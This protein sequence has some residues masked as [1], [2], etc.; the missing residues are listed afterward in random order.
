[1]QSK[2]ALLTENK[3]KIVIQH[4]RAAVS[5]TQTIISGFA[6]GISSIA[7]VKLIVQT[8]AVAE[9]ERYLEFSPYAL[10]SQH[11]RGLGT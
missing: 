3:I 9:T 8:P 6:L 4:C 1:M 7:I 5:V 11:T 2:T 10:P